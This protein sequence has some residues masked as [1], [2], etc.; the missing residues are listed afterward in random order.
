M[1][2]HEKLDVYKCSVELLA[3]SAKI[4]TEIPRGY[5]SLSD[6]LK[7]AALS[8]PLNIAEGVGKRTFQDSGRYFAI[9]RGSAMEC[10]AILDACIALSL[11]GEDK[12]KPSKILLER[13]VSMLTKMCR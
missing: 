12:I 4:N 7:R 3:Q 1:L 6:Q 9:A 5:S 8:I 10:G 11:V 13:I 2:S